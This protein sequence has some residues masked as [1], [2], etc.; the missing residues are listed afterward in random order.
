MSNPIRAW[1][2][3]TVPINEMPYPLTVSNIENSGTDDSY[4]MRISAINTE[5][6]EGPFSNY[7]ELRKTDKSKILFFCDEIEIYPF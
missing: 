6:G 7:I 4:F 5:V 2:S 1:Q 3:I